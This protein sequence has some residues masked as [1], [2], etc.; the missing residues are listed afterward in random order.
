MPPLQIED[1]TVDKENTQTQV[2][3]LRTD[4]SQM[5]QKQQQVETD[6]SKEM[7]QNKV[8]LCITWVCAYVRARVCMCVDFECRDA[9]TNIK[10]VQHQFFTILRMPILSRHM[11]SYAAH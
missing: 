9:S 10:H 5:Q 3:V 11:P 4:I 8:C 6:V 2:Q 7:P 1:V